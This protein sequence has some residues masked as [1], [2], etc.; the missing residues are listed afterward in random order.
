MAATGLARDDIQLL[1]PPWFRRF[2]GSRLTYTFG[3]LVDGI[4]DWARLGVR[5]RFPGVGSPDALR[6]IGND[7]QIIR[8]AIEGDAGYALR[9]Q[10]WLQTHQRDGSAE[11]VMRPVQALF[12]PDSTA[13]WLVNS[14]GSAARAWAFILTTDGPIVYTTGTIAQWN[15]DGFTRMFVLV[16]RCWLT[17]RINATRY[18]RRKFG[19]GHKFGDGTVFGVDMTVAQAS[20][21]L[22]TVARHKSAGSRYESVIITYSNTWPDPSAGAGADYP[23][24]QW[25][26]Y[27][28][29]VADVAVASRFSGALY[30]E[31]VT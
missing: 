2:W 18:P 12:N 31:P 10:T 3:L 24:G 27:H 26:T 20:S 29:I 23:D 14:A 30:S 15:W 8:G 5:E 4:R 1:G 11:G 6:Y 17:L 22:A 9:L 16:S 25:G 13:A 7:R 19:D 21:I 28:K